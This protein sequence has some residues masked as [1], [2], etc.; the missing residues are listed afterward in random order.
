MENLVQLAMQN[1]NFAAIMPSLVLTCFGMALLMIS[2][3]SPRGKTTHVA[4][5][6]VIALIVTGIVS[7]AAWN[8]PEFGFAGHVALDNFATFFNITFLFAAGLTILISDEYLKREGYPIGEYYALILFT[9]AGAMW[10]ASGT[11]LMTIFLGLEVLSISLYVLAGLFRGQVR[12]NEAGLK[13][14][15]L[16]AFSTGFLLYGIALIYGVSGTTNL[17]DIGMFLAAH[18]SLI[19]SPMAVAGMLLMAVG[20]LFKIAAAP[21]HMWTPDV[22]QGAPTPITAFMSAG[23][24]AA[25]FAAFLRVF[26]L[27]LGPMQGDWTSLLWLLAIL[28]MI[29]GNVIAIQQTNIKRMLAYSSIAH[30]G[31]ALVGMVAANEIGLSGILF[32]MLGYTFMNIGAFAVLVLA[33]KQGEENLTLDGFAGF[34][35]K[36]PFLGVA[37]TIFLFSLMGIPPTAGFAGK[38]YIFAGAVKAGYIWLAVIGVLNSAVSLYYYLRVMV[39]MYFKD[40]TENYEWVKLNTAAVVSIVV[41]IVGVLYLGLIPAKVMEMAKLAIF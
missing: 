12:S 15:L 18:E 17:A 30:A 9:T 23:P 35:Y 5:I 31:Y 21:F 4:W 33:G 27:G 25:A 26:T 32:Y 8:K 2:V 6:S 38:F 10:M 16:G 40:P 39:A 19:S 28:T 14:F 11:D 7:L 13:Y 34:G 36:R 22:Y 20:F 1:V 37:M 3:F 24:K 41:A 29:V